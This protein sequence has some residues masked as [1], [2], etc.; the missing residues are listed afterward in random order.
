MPTY[1]YKC[2]NCGNEIEVFQSIKDAPLT[3]CEK[4]GKDTLKKMISGGAGLIF[5]GSGFYLTD[6][7]DKK[8]SNSSTSSKKAE[9]TTPA[10]KDSAGK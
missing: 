2:E 7:K 5:K 4:C 8:T 10:P 3:K 1:D 9:T 6:Y